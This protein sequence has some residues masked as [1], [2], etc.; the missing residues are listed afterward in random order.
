M[1]PELHALRNAAWRRLMTMAALPDARRIT[2]LFA[3]DPQRAARFSARLNDLRLDFS[4]TGIDQDTL[5]V[6]IGLAR[7][8]GL[9][10]FRARLFAGVAVNT[11]EGRAAMHMALRAPDDVELNATLPGGIDAASALAR[12]ERARMRDFTWAVHDGTLRGATGATFDTVLNIGIGGSDLGPRMVVRALTMAGGARL[13]VHFLSNVDGHA[14][15]ALARNLNPERTLVLVASKTFTTAETMMNAR[16]ARDWLAG[17]LGNAAVA[18][19][20]VALSTNAKAVAAFGIVAEKTFGFRDW[21][22]GRYSLWSAIGLSIALAAGWESFQALLDG[23]WAMDC[24]FCDA[25]LEENL[26]VLLA[27]VGIWH[28]DAL[29]CGSHCVLAYDERLGLLPAF[30]Q[31]LE[32]ESNGKSV[33]LDGSPVDQPTCP[34]VFGVPGTDAQHSFMQLVHQGTSVV[35]VDFILAAT[36]DH[37]RQDAH[38]ALAANAFAQAEALLRG[39]TA[40]EAKGGMLQA[41]MTQGE[42]DRLAP[43]R[44][45]SGERPSVS[46]L[47]HRLDAFS[48]GRL[49]ALYE[50]KVAVQ[51]C[52]WGINSFDQW[53]VE[54]GKELAGALVPALTPGADPGAHDSSTTALI[55]AFRE[56]RG[57]A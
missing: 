39:R 8:A 54:L 38:R 22:G 44:A 43:H 46:I 2:P 40:E 50:H 5:G 52:I 35:P 27:L 36:P 57:E 21:V 13:A 49:I 12:A 23:A 17:A 18:Q 19:H 30:L 1:D 53:G 4:K 33:M 31:Q 26:P 28:V 34:V 32:M 48:L 6:L 15:A 45:F 20:F 42:A 37:D 10:D 29:G 47:F 55:R 56:L 14:F 51:G 25:A 41:G 24:H 3:A 16:A 9:E 7:A 11:T